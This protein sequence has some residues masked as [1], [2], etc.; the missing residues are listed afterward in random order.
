MTQEASRADSKGLQPGQECTDLLSAEEGLPKGMIIDWA[1]SWGKGKTSA[2]FECLSRTPHWRVAWVSEKGQ[3]LRQGVLSPWLFLRHRIQ[4]ERWVWIDL[5]EEP[6]FFGQGTRSKAEKKSQRDAEWVIHQL[7]RSQAFD[8]IL[9]EG[10]L[11]VSEN[12]DGKAELFYRRLQ[13]EAKRSK[14]TL[15]FLGEEPLPASLWPVGLQVFVDQDEN[16]S[17]SVR[18]LKSRG[19]SFSS[20]STRLF[21]RVKILQASWEVEE[22]RKEE[23]TDGVTKKACG[24]HLVREPA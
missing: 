19:R 3:H 15:L 10:V 21:S 5:P 7:V 11:R 9:V 16:S 17:R 12:F 8:C 18:I 20:L 4:W 24:M 13:I 23:Q 14:S 22:E 2:L 1:G 6:F